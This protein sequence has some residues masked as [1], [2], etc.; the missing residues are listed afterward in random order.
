MKLSAEQF[1]YTK[2]G[3]RKEAE[4]DWGVLGLQMLTEA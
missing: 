2:V 4:A 3:K 1:L